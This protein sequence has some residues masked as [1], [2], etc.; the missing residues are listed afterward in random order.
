MEKE[1][2]S[3][4]SLNPS[5]H[6]NYCNKLNHLL[7]I[8]LLKR[9]SSPSYATIKFKGIIEYPR[10]KT[11]K[12]IIVRSKLYNRN[13]ARELLKKIICGYCTSLFNTP[14]LLNKKNKR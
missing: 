3:P 13:P 7:K 9:D 5:S 11:C 6:F 4:I 2:L 12:P 8:G 14:Y 10:C 1:R